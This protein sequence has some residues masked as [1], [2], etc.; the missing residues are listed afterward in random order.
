METKLKSL[1]NRVFNSRPVPALLALGL[2]CFCPTVPAQSSLNDGI[3]DSWRLQYFGSGFASDARALATADPDGDGANNFQEYLG[4]TDPLNALSVPTVPLQVSTY[5]G[6]TAGNQNGFRTNATFLRPYMVTPDSMGRLFI[7]EALDGSGT[8]PASNANR[9]RVIDTNGIVSTPAGAEQSGLVD[10]PAA[11]SRFNNPTDLVFDTFGNAYI[12]DNQNHRIRKLD[13]NGIVSTFAGATLGYADG[14]GT[15]ALFRQPIGIVVDPGNNLF[16]ADFY[17]WRI[18]KI[19]PQGDVT[20]YA[21]S[22]AGSQDGNLSVATFN[23]PNDLALAPDGTLY[24]SDWANG[25]IRKISTNGVVSTL[26]SGMQYIERVSVDANGDIYAGVP[27]SAFGLYKFRPNGSLAWSLRNSS[28]YLDGSASVARFARYG[29]AFIFPDGTILLPDVDNNRLRLITVGIPPLLSITPKGG[30]FTNA[31][32]VTLTNFVTNGVLCYTTDGT[33]PTAVSPPYTGSL[34]LT[35]AATVSG[36]VF[37]NGT[38]VSD[39]AV[40]TYWRVYALEGDGIPASWRQQ[41]FGAGYLTDPRVAADAD[42]D[43]DG[44]NNLQ[45]YTIGSNPLDPNSGFRV[46]IGLVPVIQWFSVSNTVYQVKRKDSLT[47]TNWTTVLSGFR[48]TNSVSIFVDLGVTA[49]AGYYVV[50]PVP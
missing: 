8:S 11:Q 43:G 50:E 15:N 36:R 28:G 33:T 31:V 14:V 27:G 13:T 12:A 6:S 4:G 18:R 1:T 20:T 30:L 7:A 23:S 32:V 47:A 46:A 34:T 5:A 39:V 35:A 41:Y 19:T 44:A 16:V 10:G 2:I 24:V 42:P 3:P 49:P 26:A 37:V 29:Q 9:I 21:G 48:A 40:E 38:P 17:N 22:V 25:R 45:E